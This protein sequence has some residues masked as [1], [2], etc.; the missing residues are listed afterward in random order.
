M[1]DHG[2]GWDE[3][4]HEDIERMMDRTP[5]TQVQK[6]ADEAMYSAAPIADDGELVEP[7]VTLV[8]M[9]PN[10]L[11]VIA[12]GAQMYRGD[13]VDDPS[14][15][16]ISIAQ[17]DFHDM[18][19][20]TL[21]APLELVDLHFLFVGVSRSFAQQLTRQRTAVYM[22]ESL[23][24]AV[25]ENAVN[26]VVMP[27]S[28]AALDDDD[29]MRVLW[30]DHVARTAWVYNAMVNGGIPAEDARGGLLLNTATSTHYKT[31][32]RNLAEHAGMRLCSQAQHE[33]KVVWMEII[34][35]ILEYG[36]ESERWQQQAIAKLFKPVCYQTGKCEFMSSSDRWC[37]IRDRVEAHHL[38]GDHP[39]T[40]SDI[41]PH[42]PLLSFAARKAPGA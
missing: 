39:D 21:K 1:S 33:W 36:P 41:D 22:M 11:R 4:M 12:A 13:V 42:E 14:E 6:W 19:R 5:G 31:N 27:P 2:T 32:L 10:P 35:A 34:K 26:D 8:S 7:K 3:N 20:T 28:I 40:W 30:H 23:R 37:R 15:I 17:Q 18:S 25:K 9:T 24:F 29:P 38:A 16:P